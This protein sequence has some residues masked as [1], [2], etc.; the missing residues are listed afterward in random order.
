M[1]GCHDTDRRLDAAFHLTRAESN[2]SNC[3]PGAADGRLDGIPPAG[4]NGN[5]V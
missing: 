3:F 4:K 2:Q 5:P 1:K